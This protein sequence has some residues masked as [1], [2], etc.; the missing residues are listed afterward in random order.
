MPAHRSVRPPFSMRHAF[1]LA[2]DLAL[3]RDPVQ[4]LLVP[5][6]LR[7]PWMIAFGW[8]AH[9]DEVAPS[10]A[11]HMFAAVALLGQ[12]M[13][14]W[15]VD[16]M[17]RFRARSVYNTSADTRPAS[18]RECYA[19]GFAR[20]PWLYLTEF[21]RN[22][23]LGIGYGFFVLPGVLLS[24][25]LAFGTEAVVL[26]QRDLSAAFRRSFQ[27]SQSRFERWLEMIAASVSLALAVLFVT[28]TLYLVIGP[29]SAWWAWLLVGSL[30]AAAIWPV[31]QYAW[32]FF[33]LRLV[34]VETPAVSSRSPGAR[35]GATAGPTGRAPEPVDRQAPTVAI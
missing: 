21:V 24:Y 3:R 23:A 8:L 26:D 33:Y 17:L 10:A 7:A 18:A 1:A 15:A 9:R 22:I 13:A 16:A 2:F 32:T 29:T 11:T 25:R 5:W 30:I 34:E 20:L 19:R 31:I 27:L 35:P 6:L 4:S 28:V 12:S 14:W